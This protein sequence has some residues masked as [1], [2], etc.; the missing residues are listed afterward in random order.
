M[1]E[2]RAGIYKHYKGGLYVAYGVAYHSETEEKLI[3]YAPLGVHEKS[4]ITVRPYNMFF[5]V[6]E[7]DG[8]ERPRFEFVDATITPEL[9]GQYDQSSGP[10][11]EDIADD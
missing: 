6:V 3:A 10:E 2:F 11:A 5:E 1:S 8:T 7:V 4:N 9:T